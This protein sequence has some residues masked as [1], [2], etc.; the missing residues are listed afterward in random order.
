MSTVDWVDE[1]APRDRYLAPPEVCD[2]LRPEARGASA[3]DRASL[4]TTHASWVVIGGTEVWKLKRPVDL[5]FLDF[6]TVMARRQA[7]EDEVRLNRRLAPDVY[8]GVEPV[9]RTL[10][11]HAVVGEGP[12]VDW[13]VRMRRLPDHCCASALLRDGRLDGDMLARL[14]ERLATFFATA[15][16][17][18][19]FGSAEALRANVEENFAQVAPLVGVV[20][21]GKT[22]DDIRKFQLEMLDGGA[23]RF[24]ARVAGGR[25]REGHGD[26]RLEHVYFLPPS[27]IRVIDC[28]EFNERFRCGDVAGE[29]A[30]LA[31]ELEAAER[32][33][34][35]AGFLARF[36][37]AAQDFDLYQVIDFY[38]SYRAFVR[39]K[40]AAFVAADPGTP[41]EVRREKEEEART[42]FA[43]SRAV[44]GRELMTPFVVAVGGMIGSG[45]STLAS[46][47]GRALSVPVVSSDRTR[48][49]MAGVAETARG[50]RTLY[51]PRR[52]EA[53]YEEV[54]RRAAMVVGAGR[55]VVIDATFAERRWRNAAA[56]LARQAGASFA[57][58]EAV[59]AD[60]EKLRQ[61]LA[62]RRDHRS[63]SDATEAELDILMPRY[64]G[65]DATDPGP[66]LT[67]DTAGPA[68]SAEAAATGGL[69]AVGIPAFMSRAG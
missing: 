24:A 18:L 19:S 47:L 65:R 52:I 1:A 59:C 68:V 46:A 5:G 16:P 3:E 31:M 38:L 9:R 50:D 29:V 61:R 27:T 60:E 54:L 12:I 48:K 45:K 22:Y 7:C 53:T 15:R 57:F 64:Q 20:L 4:K 17:T 6:R 49:F 51:E 2:L 44:S 69:R 39:G 30:F 14:A 41:P 58:V 55:G 56:A 36:A 43:L 23:A 42:L 34:L 40:V 28:I 63:V 25:I 35:A 8:L 62:G 33:E 10:Q 32:P 37:E 26:L 13:A 21:D 11:G 67:V 66:W